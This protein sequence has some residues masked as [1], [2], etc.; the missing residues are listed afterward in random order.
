MAET[1]VNHGRVLPHR[2]LNP[3]QN[4]RANRRRPRAPLP[5]NR[6]APRLDANVISGDTRHIQRRDVFGEWEKFTFVLQ[7]NQ[8][9]RHRLLSHGTMFGRA[10]QRQKF[11]AGIRTL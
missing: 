11:G 3:L 8:R 4:R 7:Q 6:P 2:L 1:V 9:F 10:N 5:L